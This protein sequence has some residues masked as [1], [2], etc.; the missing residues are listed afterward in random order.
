[1]KHMPC[2]IDKCILLPVCLS[3]VVIDCQKMRD[4]YGHLKHMRRIHGAELWEVFNAVLPN[5]RTLKGPIRLMESKVYK[6]H[7]YERN[8]YYH[9]TNS[10]H[11]Q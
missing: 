6:V 8:D 1:M 11:K 10:V 3:K 4:Y 7:K 9:G 2:K 5:M